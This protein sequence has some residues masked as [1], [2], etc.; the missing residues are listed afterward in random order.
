MSPPVLRCCRASRRSYLHQ[1]GEKLDVHQ[2]GEE[3]D[4]HQASEELD[5]HQADE[6]RR[7]QS[8][9]LDVAEGDAAAPK[10]AGATCIRR[11]RSWMRYGASAPAFLILDVGAGAA[12]GG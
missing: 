3:L 5:V 12:S 9:G 11:V 10:C 4:L 6:V 2:A 1:A 7:L 8:R